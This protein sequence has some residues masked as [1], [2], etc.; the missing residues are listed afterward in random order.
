L[1][2]IPYKP[3]FIHRLLVIFYKQNKYIFLLI[4]S[5]YINVRNIKKHQESIAF[6]MHFHII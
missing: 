2:I 4:K 6:F 1:Y 3:I 5:H